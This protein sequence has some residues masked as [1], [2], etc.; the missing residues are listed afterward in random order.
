MLAGSDVEPAPR[1]RHGAQLHDDVRDPLHRRQAGEHAHSRRVGARRAFGPVRSRRRSPSAK[2]VVDGELFRVRARPCGNFDDVFPPTATIACDVRRKPSAERV[3]S[4]LSGSWN[5]SARRRRLE[6]AADRRPSRRLAYGRCW[7]R[8][9]CR[10]G[11]CA[12]AG[13]TAR[14]PPQR[15]KRRDARAGKFASSVGT[16]LA[17]EAVASGRS[18]GVTI[19]TARPSATRCRPRR[20]AKCC[21]PAS[22]CASSRIQIRA[23]HG[24][25]HSHSMRQNGRLAASQ[26]DHPRARRRA[27]DD[28]TLASV[29]GAD[30]P[31]LG[32][33]P[34]R[35]LLD[36]RHRRARR[37]TGR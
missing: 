3:R 23:R 29:E 2:K 5:S 4:A 8:P 7:P 10:P 14:C 33:R 11:R 13:A 31:R 24:Q 25:N 9:A 36:R 21:P 15:R 28:E 32:G 12:I 16:P 6:A 17:T 35:R 20:S 19:A 37:G 22:M 30:L 34:R 18:G 27:L 26:R 1:A